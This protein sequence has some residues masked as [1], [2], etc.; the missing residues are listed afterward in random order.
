MQRVKLAC[1]N[2]VSHLDTMVAGGLNK[3]PLDV[4]SIV[5]GDKTHWDVLLLYMPNGAEAVHIANPNV[6]V[7]LSGLSYDRDLSFL[8]NQ[9]V[10][11][12]FTRKLV[13]EVHRYGFTDAKIWEY[14][15][16]NQACVNV[17]DIFM[18]SAGFLL[19][20]GWPLFFSEFGMDLRGT[21][22]QLNRY[23]NCFF[24]LAAE[25]DFD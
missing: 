23:M 2:W 11:L 18:R 24:A 4:V 9:S 5:Y 14:S 7:I 21:N 25:L 13:F 6:L 12:T 10:N 8:Q 1:V 19:E 15:N 22:E 17:V 3:Q 16:A 20:Q